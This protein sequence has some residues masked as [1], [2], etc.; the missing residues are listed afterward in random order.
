MTCG[1]NPHEC[2]VLTD[3]TEIMYRY[4]GNMYRYKVSE[5]SEIIQVP[6]S[7]NYF[8]ASPPYAWAGLVP[9]HEI[10]FLPSPPTAG[11]GLVPAH[12]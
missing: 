7:N 12:K 2:Q 10:Y 5:V 1:E 11:A 8:L 4:K 3:T 9:V 6:H